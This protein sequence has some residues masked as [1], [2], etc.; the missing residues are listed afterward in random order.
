MFGSTNTTS[1]WSCLWSVM[2]YL[3]TDVKNC[4]LSHATDQAKYELGFAMFFLSNN[5]QVL[6]VSSNQRNLVVMLFDFL[7]LFAKKAIY[8]PL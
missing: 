3:T 8:V 5:F 6:D 7:F 4:A 1:K 2:V